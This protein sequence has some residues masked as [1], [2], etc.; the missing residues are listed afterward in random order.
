VLVDVFSSGSEFQGVWTSIEITIAPAFVLTQEQTASENGTL[1]AWV[2]EKK[3][4]TQVLRKK[5]FDRQ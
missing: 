2:L 1:W 5:E 4:D 3:I